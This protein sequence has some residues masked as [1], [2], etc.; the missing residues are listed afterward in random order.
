MANPSGNLESELQLLSRS[1]L[2]EDL[3][4]VHDFKEVERAVTT[5]GNPVTITLRWWG[6]EDRRQSL[7]IHEFQG[8]ELL[9]FDPTRELAGRLQAEG[10]EI[11]TT[12]SDGM[13]LVSRETV[14]SWFAERDAL[15]LLPSPLKE[16]GF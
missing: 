8:S 1:L 16:G 12:S 9:L 2:G 3:T 6:D 14:E 5:D 15:G 4:Q 7:V 13:F 11:Q 10:H